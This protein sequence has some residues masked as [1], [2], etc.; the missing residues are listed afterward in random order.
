MIEDIDVAMNDDP[1][2]YGEVTLEDNPDLFHLICGDREWGRAMREGRSDEYEAE[3]LAGRTGRCP[4]CSY[5]MTEE[6]S[7]PWYITRSCSV[8][9]PKI[10]MPR[11]LK[12]SEIEHVCPLC[13]E[14]RPS[15]KTPYTGYYYRPRLMRLHGIGVIYNA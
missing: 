10:D 1:D 8:R 2:G 12:W 4:Q 9:D 6:E 5:P 11:E 13:V 14:E 3:L 7:T 15:G